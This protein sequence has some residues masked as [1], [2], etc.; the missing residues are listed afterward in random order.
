[1][2]GVEGA[3]ASAMQCYTGLPSKAPLMLRH[4]QLANGS[5]CRHGVIDGTG[6]HTCVA[7]A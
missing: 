6:V 3:I 7:F 4:A 1:V 2:A 5:L